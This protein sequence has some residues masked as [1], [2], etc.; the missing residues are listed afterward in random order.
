MDVTAGNPAVVVTACHSFLTVPHAQHCQP[1]PDGHHL[2]VVK[3]QLVSIS[4]ASPGGCVWLA[5]SVRHLQMARA[6]NSRI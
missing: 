4:C 6:A 5:S 3:G 2:D 1:S